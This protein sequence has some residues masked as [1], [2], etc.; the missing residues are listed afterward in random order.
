MMEKNLLYY[1]ERQKKESWNV[2]SPEMVLK[3]CQKGE[4]DKNY[5][6]YLLSNIA[7]TAMDL[8]REKK[9]LTYYC[10]LHPKNKKLF[11]FLEFYIVSS[12]NYSIRFQCILLGQLY[13]PEKIKKI[14]NDVFQSESN[15]I[16][17]ILTS[18]R[19]SEEYVLLRYLATCVN[20]P[21]YQLFMYFKWFFDKYYFYMNLW[22]RRI[23]GRYNQF[24]GNLAFKIQ[25]YDGEEN[26]YEISRNTEVIKDLTYEDLDLKN[27]IDAELNSIYYKTTKRII[28]IHDINKGYCFGISYNFFRKI[29]RRLNKL[30][31]ITEEDY[32]FSFIRNK[33]VYFLHIDIPA[34]Q[35]E[36]LLPAR[37]CKK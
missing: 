1:A 12:D 10:K 37:R 32:F 29:T 15:F 36:L 19:Y 28:N 8:E 17:N 34:I 35:L 24:H 26:I 9:A 21:I 31:K 13:F 7:E 14:V 5:A 11:S 27:T 20:A 22:Q 3:Y 25:S 4:I 16:E 6:L 33:S 2:E 23:F 18:R 30:F